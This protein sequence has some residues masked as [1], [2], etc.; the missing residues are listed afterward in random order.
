MGKEERHLGMNAKRPFLIAVFLCGLV[1]GSFPVSALA[2][3]TAGSK[4]LSDKID[5]ATNPRIT[6][7]DVVAITVYPAEEYNREVTVQPD[8]R[9]ELALI[10]S[11]MV[12]DLTARELQD[13]LEVRYSKYVDNPR[14]TIAIRHFAGRRVAIFGEVH[15]SGFFEYRDG[16]KLLELIAMAG[17]FTD[18]ARTTRIGILRAGAP[19]GTTFNFQVVLD[20]ELSRDLPLQPGDT[21]YVPK[22]P[23]NKK[24]T[25]MTNNILPWLSLAALCASLALLAKQ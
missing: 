20:G 22:T 7:G 12:K 14:V 10:G 23:V 11:L 19:E 6:P 2:A 16:M 4:P 25:W 1:A 18:N 24:A 3:D 5:A 17:G 8:G 21:I 13:L 15:S 9:I